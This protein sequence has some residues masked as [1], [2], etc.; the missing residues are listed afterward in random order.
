MEV[1]IQDPRYRTL[2]CIA[3][4]TDL[5]DESLNLQVTSSPSPNHCILFSHLSLTKQV[6]FLQSTL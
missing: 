6:G 4:K 3:Y 2:I 5:T 1:L